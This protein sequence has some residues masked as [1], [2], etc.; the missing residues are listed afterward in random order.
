MAIRVLARSDE[1]SKE[2]TKAQQTISDFLRRFLVSD[3]KTKPAERRQVQML[4][5]YLSLAEGGVALERAN[6]L[7]FALEYYEQWFT[8]SQFTNRVFQANKTELQYARTRWVVCKRRLGEVTSGAQSEK[9]LQEAVAFARQWNLRNANHPETPKL[10]PLVVTTSLVDVIAAAAI[11]FPKDK[12][13]EDIPE[14]PV[15]SPRRDFNVS[16][17]M[18]L[19]ELSLQGQL[20]RRKQRLMLTDRENE[21]HVV[22]GPEQVSSQDL[23]VVENSSGRWQIAEWGLLCE[24]E[25]DGESVK[26]RFFDLGSEELYFGIEL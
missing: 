2:E 10:D 11:K 25:R 18:Q 3:R 26:V 24:L 22:C 7:T 12:V 20:Q 9:H 15:E 14:R 19:K 21:D 23:Q 6:R 1:L 8:E 5:K 17:E 4:L 16:F 13:S